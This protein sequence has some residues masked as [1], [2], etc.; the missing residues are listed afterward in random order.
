[1]RLLT[2][3]CIACSL[4]PACAATAADQPYKG[5]G[6]AMHGDLKYGPDFKHFDYVNP[7]A[8]KGGDLRRYGLGTFDSFNPFIIKGNPDLGSAQ[9]YDTLLTP[10]A[11]EPFSEYGLLA[12]TIETPA[13]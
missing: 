8:P 3:V 13:D 6:I 7:A 2:A 5:H 1:M 9:T 11:D 12:E 4:L 10:S